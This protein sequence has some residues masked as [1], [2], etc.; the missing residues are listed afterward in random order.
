MIT[1]LPLQA[2]QRRLEE[3][4]VTFRELEQQGIKLEKLLRDE[5]GKVRVDGAPQPPYR[6]GLRPTHNPPAPQAPRP[7]RRRS[8]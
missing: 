2:I 6:W 8:G 1:A 4:E 3:I 5:G 7:T